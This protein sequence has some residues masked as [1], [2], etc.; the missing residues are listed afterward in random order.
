MMTY[1]QLLEIYN[2]PEGGSSCSDSE[3]AVKKILTPKPLKN[4]KE[5]T[6]ISSSKFRY[7]G[8]GKWV[9]II[10]ESENS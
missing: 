7:T 3:A 10:K 4:I 8:P 2:G 5:L 9:K 6:E 1:K